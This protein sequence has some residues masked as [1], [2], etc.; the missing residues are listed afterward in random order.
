MDTCSRRCHRRITLTSAT[1]ITPASPAQGPNGNGDYTWVKF[2]CK[3]LLQAGQY[4]VHFNTAVRIPTNM[5][6]PYRAGIPT[7][8]PCSHGDI[9]SMHGAAHLR[10]CTHKADGGLAGRF[11]N[12][13]TED[14]M[15]SNPRSAA[16]NSGAAAIRRA[17]A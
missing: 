5:G 8:S 10:Q 3:Y 1:L 17:L 11:V 14:A 2:R 4:S 6:L 15:S 16:S 7:P 13:G 9:A 12:S